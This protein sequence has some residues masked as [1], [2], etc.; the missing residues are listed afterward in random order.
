MTIEEL[1]ISDI[2]LCVLQASTDGENTACYQVS[3]PGFYLRIK[4]QNGTMFKQFVI[5][6]DELDTEWGMDGVIAK[7]RRYWFWRSKTAIDDAE[8]PE[9]IQLVRDGWARHQRL[10]EGPPVTPKAQVDI[11]LSPST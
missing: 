11:R 4:E 3:N 2:P 6:P 5:S 9:K 10:L 8:S 7:E 1:A